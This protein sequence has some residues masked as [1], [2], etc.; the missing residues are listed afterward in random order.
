MIDFDALLN[1]PIYDV[2]AEPV[3]YA[4]PDE[5]PFDVRGVFD[6]RHLPIEFTDGAAMSAEQVT[7]RVRLSDFPARVSP[8]QG[9]RLQL[10]GATWFVQDVQNLGEGE[11]T[12]VLSARSPIDG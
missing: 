2:F 4:R 10:R 8:G 9:D 6:H 7:L 3:L 12:L 1:A 5:P 11:A